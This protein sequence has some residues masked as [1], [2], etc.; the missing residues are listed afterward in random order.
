MCKSVASGLLM[1]LLTVRAPPLALLPESH[2]LLQRYSLQELNRPAWP[3]R[4]P[5]GWL[6]GRAADGV[7]VVARLFLFALS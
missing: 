3:G 5:Q 6:T 7:T 1:D 2:P 4:I